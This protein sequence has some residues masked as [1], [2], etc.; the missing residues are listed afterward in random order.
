VPVE[1][2]TFILPNQQEIHAPGAASVR[3]AKP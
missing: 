1:E 3:K 2:P